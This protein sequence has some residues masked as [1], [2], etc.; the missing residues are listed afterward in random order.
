MP[1]YGVSSV[2]GCELLERVW[3][4]QTRELHVIVDSWMAIASGV[5]AF[6]SEVSG[7]IDQAERQYGLANRSYPE[8]VIERLGVCHNCVLTIMQLHAGCVGIGRLLQ[9]Y[10]SMCG[11]LLLQNSQIPALDFFD[12]VDQ[13]Y[14]VDPDGPISGYEESV[15]F[16][17]VSQWYTII[18]TKHLI[19]VGCL[20]TVEL[21]SMNKTLHSIS[22]LTLI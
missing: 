19:L 6:F 21:T 16:Y 9:V 15:Q 17:K 14:G 12:S 2:L 10:W 13:T 1:L 20:I 8:Y 5:G 4:R 22:T 11:C 7:L 18:W 3:L